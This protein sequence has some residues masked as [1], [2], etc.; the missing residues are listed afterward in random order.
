M[1]IWAHTVPYTV[2]A[3][4]RPYHN[5]SRNW[6][7]RCH[8]PPTSLT[9]IILWSNCQKMGQVCLLTRKLGLINPFS[10]RFN[11]S[12]ER[13]SNCHNQIC[14][15][16]HHILHCRYPPN[17]SSSTCR[18]CGVA[19]ME[20]MRRCMSSAISS[21]SRKCTRGPIGLVG[22]LFFFKLS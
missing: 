2:W 19:R 7:Q 14:E 4:F 10:I 12:K 17:Q 20:S 5:R 21:A 1:V 22:I 6:A 13:C 9:S 18:R 16:F 3:I 8:T 15:V 11:V